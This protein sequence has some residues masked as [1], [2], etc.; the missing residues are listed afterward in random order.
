M[1]R[2]LVVE[3]DK[4]IAD[5]IAH[6]LQKAGHV[7]DM[8]SSGALVMPRIS[9]ARPDLIVLDLMLPGMD[10]M[11]ICKALRQQPATAAIPIIML[12]ARGEEVDRVAGLELGAD[13]YV[14]KPFSPKE[15]VARVGARG[16]RVQRSA[17]GDVL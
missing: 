10:G 7:V 14:T 3:D 16:G 2:V 9:S 17:P 12:T 5:L 13:D 1:S 8:L 4:D 15:L 6:Y 11:Q